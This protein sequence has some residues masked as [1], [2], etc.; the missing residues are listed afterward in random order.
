MKNATGPMI[1]QFIVVFRATAL[2][3][4]LAVCVMMP[5]GA[6]A[7]VP[8]TEA[9]ARAGCANILDYDADPR[10]TRDNAKAF[11]TAVDANHDGSICIYFPAG[12]YRFFSHPVVSLLSDVKHAGASIT[13]KGDGSEVSTLLFNA[14]V[15]GLELELNGPRQSFHVRDLSIQAKGR[16]KTTTGLSVVQNNASSPNP[17]QSDISGVSIHG[18]DGFGAEERFARGVYLHQVSNVTITNSAIAGS[19]EGNPYASEGFCLYLSGTA[20]SPPVQINIIGSQINYCGTGI[21]YG[22]YVQGVQIVASNFVGNNI[23]IY[24]PKDNKGNDQLS[25]LGSQFNSGTSNIILSAPIDGVSI[26]GNDFYLTEKGKY[27]IEIPGIQ[28]AITAN[29]FI[30]LGKPKTTALSIGS[31]ML[32]AG[33]ITGNSFNNF[34]VAIWLQSSSSRVNVQSNAYSDIRSDKVRDKGFGNT[35]GGGSL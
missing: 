20:P 24:Q 14:D 4:A 21:F 5:S 31:F 7:R 33:I 17:A 23:A 19:A 9:P 16:G 2:A 29:C 12:T 13:I 32:D 18:Q 15:G 8:Q 35:V 27:S 11:A 34:N 26:T 28:F 10:G 25:I 22:P 30:Q 6:K 3:Y 1:D